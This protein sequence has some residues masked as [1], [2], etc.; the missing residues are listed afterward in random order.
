VLS[1]QQDE[2]VSIR[3]VW[4]SFNLKRFK[5]WL[6]KSGISQSDLFIGGCPRFRDRCRR[7]SQTSHV[8]RKSENGIE[9]SE[10]FSRRY[11]TFNTALNHLSMPTQT[12]V[13]TRE[14]TEYCWGNGIVAKFVPDWESWKLRL[15]T[16][17]PIQSCDGWETFWDWIMFWNGTFWE[18]FDDLTNNGPPQKVG[19]WRIAF[20]TA[21]SR[22]S[23]LIFESKICCN[24]NFVQE[25]A[26][27]DNF[28]TDGY[29]VR[30]VKR[31]KENLRV[32][33]K[34]SV[35]VVVY[36]NIWFNFT[37]KMI[38]LWFNVKTFIL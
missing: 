37:H 4:I 35:F 12:F 36:Q 28:V 19:K 16:T 8:L 29:I 33:T 24:F 18:F 21:I 20:W 14:V 27:L 30:T 3:K 6:V 17:V 1:V 22:E 10:E 2:I 9:Y 31:E 11:G 25:N 38:W 5:F 7:E 32:A 13:E 34:K 26:H 23:W 15:S